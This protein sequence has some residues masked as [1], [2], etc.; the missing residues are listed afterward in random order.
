MIK[1]VKEYSKKVCV[2]EKQKE[3][4]TIGVIGQP[5]TGKSSLIKILYKEKVEAKEGEARLGREFIRLH[6]NIALLSN[7]G[8]TFPPLD[9]FEKLV[10]RQAIKIEEIKDPIGIIPALIEKVEKLELLR[11]YRIADFKNPEEFL[12]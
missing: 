10:L 9:Q 5:N 11:H 12:E 3:Y 7:K 4:I 1:A 2:K 6:K 8:L